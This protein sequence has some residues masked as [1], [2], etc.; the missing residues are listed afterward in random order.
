MENLKDVCSFC[1]RKTPYYCRNTRDMS[2]TDGANH[3][4]VCHS[5]L[6]LAGGGERRE[7]GRKKQR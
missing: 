2:P 1:G 3:D 5:A 6:A 7:V 4:P